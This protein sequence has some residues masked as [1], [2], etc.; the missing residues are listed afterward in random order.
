MILCHWF[1]D[2]EPEQYMLK[3]PC[4]PKPAHIKLNLHTIYTA[5]HLG[6]LK[7][8]EYICNFLPNELYFLR[9]ATL[10]QVV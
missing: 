7:L 5:K 3:A 8:W 4:S 2:C 9:Q 6:L 1:D 10:R